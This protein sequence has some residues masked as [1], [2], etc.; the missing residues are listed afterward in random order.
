MR[1][2]NEQDTVCNMLYPL[3]LV[4]F[5]RTSPSPPGRPSS[6]RFAY[7]LAVSGGS[8]GDNGNEKIQQDLRYG[9]VCTK[10]LY[11]EIFGLHG[12]YGGA[13]SYSRAGTDIDEHQ[14]VSNTSWAR[15]LVA[16]LIQPAVG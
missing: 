1:W 8:W 16:D 2:A 7:R 11:Y 5:S 6:N 10:W 3:W 9:R 12:K 4:H 14:R 13:S 15:S